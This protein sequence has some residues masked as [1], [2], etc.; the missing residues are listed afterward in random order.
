MAGSELLTAQDS[1]LTQPWLGLAPDL[2]A[3]LS[4]PKYQTQTTTRCSLNRGKRNQ[5][6]EVQRPQRNNTKRYTLKLTC[7]GYSQGAQSRKGKGP[8]SPNI[9]EAQI[10]R[11]GAAPALG[12]GGEQLDS[13]PVV[14]QGKILPKPRS[15][16]KSLHSKPMKG[17]PGQPENT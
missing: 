8:P 15:I 4:W 6:A 17:L 5:K 10:R 16:E 1:P 13:C 14:S 7:T 2:E 9:R 11:P 3:T 12:E